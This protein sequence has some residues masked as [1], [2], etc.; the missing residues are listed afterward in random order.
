MNFL[1]RRQVTIVALVVLIG[2]AGYLNWQYTKDL[3]MQ[4]A[5]SVMNSAQQEES[6]NINYGET[7]LVD[8]KATVVD[9]FFAQAKLNREK[10]R[11][12]A[13]DLLNSVIDNKNSDSEGVK[14]AQ[15]EIVKISAEIEQETTVESLIEAKGLGKSVV[16]ISD[17]TVN[18]ILDT[19]DVKGVDTAKIQDIVVG[20]TGVSSDK[21]KI[22]G[23]NN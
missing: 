21:I 6:E 2:V 4:D 23:I 20:E 11:G 12:E 1:K 3:P 15:D 9:D 10:S 22:L 5:V 17:N 14:K 19:P 13:L 18:I 8:G 7:T 16:Y